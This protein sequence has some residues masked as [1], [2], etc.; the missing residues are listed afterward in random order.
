M[1]AAYRM[2][3]VGLSVAG[4]LTLPAVAG[5]ASGGFTVS[6]RVPVRCVIST[7]SDV[8]AVDGQVT[9]GTVT[10]SCNKAGGYTVVANYRPLDADEDAVLVYGGATITLPHD[11][12]AV[13]KTS[14]WADIAAIGYQFQNAHLHQP[15]ALA[16]SI[17]PS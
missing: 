7:P 14:N 1:A 13:I 3:K 8:V 10:E 15:L 6:V 11:G 17:N 4:L 9:Q 16:L 2:L 12:Q 5:A